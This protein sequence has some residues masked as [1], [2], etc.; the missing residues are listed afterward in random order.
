MRRNKLFVF[1]VLLCLWAAGSLYPCSI[2][3]IASPPPV[4]AQ[5]VAGTVSGWDWD[6]FGIIEGNHMLPP[7]SKSIE[8]ATIVLSLRAETRLFTEKDIR[9]EINYGHDP[10]QL[11]GFVTGFKCGDEVARTKSD[12]TG[13][14]S[15]PDVKPGSYCLAVAHPPWKKSSSGRPV[16]FL[17]DI[18]PS[19]AKGI[20]LADVRELM[21][22]CSG[23]PDLKLRKQV[24]RKP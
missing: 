15:I 5:E 3:I 4:V 9:P 7:Q 12:S 17:L 22:D 23:G 20:L 21:A 2:I 18:S 10:K 14:F 24:E 6:S 11:I 8:G 13:G 1:M 19:A 16:E